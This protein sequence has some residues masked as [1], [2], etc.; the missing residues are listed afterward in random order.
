VIQS[1][2]GAGV[3]AAAI[4]SSGDIPVAADFNGDGKTDSAVWHPADGTW[5]VL[6]TGG[7][8]QPT[9]QQLG[10]TGDVPV[11]G[12]LMAM[13]KPITQCGV[14]RMEPGTNCK[15]ARAAR[16]LRSNSVWQAIRP[17]T[18]ERGCSRMRFSLDLPAIS[19]PSRWPEM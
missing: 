13:A 8:T 1:S 15:A 5:H 18:R 2:N 4:G 17:R 11:T 16:P 14:L 19:A 9:V 7:G 12:D 6:L 3:Q 10:L